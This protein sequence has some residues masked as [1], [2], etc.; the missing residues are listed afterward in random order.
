MKITH[1]GLL[2]VYLLAIA[3]CSPNHKNTE[4]S[5]AASVAKPVVITPVTIDLS[6]PDRTL[7]TLFALQDFMEVS[8]YNESVKRQNEREEGRSESTKATFLRSGAQLFDG[9]A[10]QAFD[11]RFPTHSDV[12]PRESFEREI[13]KITNETETRSVATVNIKNITPLPPGAVPSEHDKKRRD[14]GVEYQYILTKT[15]EGWKIEDIK[16]WDYVLGS[17]RDGGYRESFVRIY[18]LNG[19]NQGPSVPSHTSPFL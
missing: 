19:V 10:K 14:K 17:A 11:K 13:L 15:S 9:I 8:R 16:Q 4:Q 6:S 12:Y 7:K 1:G 5:E 18:Q 3:A 2:A